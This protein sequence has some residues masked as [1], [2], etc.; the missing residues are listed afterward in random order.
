MEDEAR[1]A[2]VNKLT[3]K[4]KVPNYLDF[5]YMDALEEVASDR[6]TIIR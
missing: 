3:S 5:V 4:T 2:I 6:V 1:W